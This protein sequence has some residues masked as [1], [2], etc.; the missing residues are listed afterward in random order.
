MPAMRSAP[1]PALEFPS[2]DIERFWKAEALSSL[3]RWDDAAPLYQE[4]ATDGPALLR[5]AAAIGRAEALHALGRADEALPILAK[6]EAHSPSTIVRL[7]LAELYLDNK[8]IEP[9]RKLLAHSKPATLAETR[10]RQYVEGRLDLAQNKDATAI[11]DF[12]ALLGDPRGLTPALHAGATIGLAEARMALNGVETADNVLEDFI[13]QHPDSPYLDE[14]FRR[15]DA[16]YAS[17]EN[18]SDSDLEHWAAQ[19]PPSRAALALYYEARSLQRQ[20][21]EEKAIRAWTEYLRRFP[22][23]RF[24]FEAWMQ[25]GQLDLNTGRI[26]TAIT[27]FEDAMRYSGNALERARG[28]IATGNAYFAQG[29]FLLAAGDFHNAASRSPDLWLEATYDSALAWLH[30]GNYDRFLEDYTALSQRYPETDERR[31]LLL[32]EGLLQ[33][34]SGDPR[35]KATLAILHSRLSR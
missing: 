1:S 16:I 12:Q 34:R 14:M 19:P 2:S 15:L 4:V 24:A 11:E 9:A 23:H 17:E 26:P 31:N 21:R 3:G 20:G 10:W 32:E 25:L 30:L 29:E 6:L 18:P 28:E 27:A 5:Q 7:R 8:R 35:A 22:G 13:S 33:A